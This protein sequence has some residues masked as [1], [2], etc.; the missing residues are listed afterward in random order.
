MKT[1]GTP[2]SAAESVFEPVLHLLATH[3]EKMDMKMVLDLL[4]PL[5]TVREL[6]TFLIKSTRKQLSQQRMRKAERKVQRAR[7]DQVERD[8]VHLHERRVKITDGR[9]CPMCH[10][11]LGISAI[12]VHSPR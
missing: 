2:P 4:P 10:K 12:A 11:R 1:K 8:L 6:E 9:V 7:M 5:L 3:G